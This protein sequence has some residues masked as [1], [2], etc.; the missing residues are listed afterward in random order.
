M[1]FGGND[2][3]LE[4]PLEGKE[5]STLSS[6]KSAVKPKMCARKLERTIET[7]SFVEVKTGLPVLANFTVKGFF[8]FLIMLVISFTRSLSVS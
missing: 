6:F 8:S 1:I 4:V 2:G 5:S 7:L 3:D